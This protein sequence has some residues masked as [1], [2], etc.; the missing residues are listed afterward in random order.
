MI[1]NFRHKGLKKLFL[2]DDPAT[3]PAAF[4]EKIHAILL[5]L[6]SVQQERELNT[7]FC[8]CHK[9]KGDL[10]GYYAMSVSANWRIIFRYDAE[11][12]AVYNVDLI[13]Y[14]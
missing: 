3:V 6:D 1:R 5:F 12:A 4:A 13:D 14:H 10:S 7:R 8:Q 9:L 2:Y 11:E